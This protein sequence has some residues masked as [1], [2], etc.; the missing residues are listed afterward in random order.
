MNAP[1]HNSPAVAASEATISS[2]PRLVVYAGNGVRPSVMMVAILFLM[3]PGILG[4]L[5]I[6]WLVPAGEADL[7]GMYAP[8]LFWGVLALIMTYFSVVVPLLRRRLV[9]WGDLVEGRVTHAETTTTRNLTTHAIRYS[10][11]PHHAAHPVECTEKTTRK[12][13]RV[14]QE[15]DAIHVIYDPARASRSLVVEWADYRPQAL[16][17]QRHALVG[18]LRAAVILLLIIASPCLMVASE[19]DGNQQMASA[20]PPFTW[21][22]T[23]IIVLVLGGLAWVARSSGMRRPESAPAALG[24]V[25][26]WNILLVVSLGL[27]SFSGLLAAN[28]RLPSESRQL[29]LVVSAR[30]CLSV[31]LQEQVCLVEFKVPPELVSYALVRGTIFTELGNPVDREQRVTWYSGALGVPRVEGMPSSLYRRGEEGLGD[32]RIHKQLTVGEA[33][34]RGQLEARG[35]FSPSSGSLAQLRSWGVKLNV[36]P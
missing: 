10:Y 23:L 11:V 19:L 28:R 34:Q 18:P 4:P 7:D 31:Q 26:L 3:L 36:L 25:H 17:D 8:S 22:R 14:L 15:G 13:G 6:K 1:V 30:F 5:A 9:Q 35:H 24:S 29:S 16:V 12:V 27:A 21:L 20:G 2:V 33:A 32:I